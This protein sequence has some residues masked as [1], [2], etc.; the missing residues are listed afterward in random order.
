MLLCPDD[1]VKCKCCWGRREKWA[2]SENE[3]AQ[4]GKE[5]PTIILDLVINVLKYGEIKP[6]WTRIGCSVYNFGTR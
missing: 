3:W 1:E 5:R 2:E 6:E 4:S